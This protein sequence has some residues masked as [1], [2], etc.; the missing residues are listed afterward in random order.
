MAA[1]PNRGQRSQAP[2]KSDGL[3][4]QTQDQLV[5]T[6]GKLIEAVMTMQEPMTDALRKTFAMAGD[7]I[8]TGQRVAPLD[9]LV[10]IQLDLVHKLFDLQV[11]LVKM[12]FE[13]QSDLVK[14]T[15]RVLQPDSDTSSPATASTTI[16]LRRSPEEHP[17]AATTAP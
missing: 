16:D 17:A 15:H 11:G 4:Q 2:P 9:K 10:E 14:T 5:D 6:Q 3:I 1:N 7:V 13:A 12:V 8:S